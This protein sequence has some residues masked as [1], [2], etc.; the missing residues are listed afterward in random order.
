MIINLDCYRCPKCN[1]A[2]DFESNTKYSKICP[3]CKVEMNFFMNWDK[4]TEKAKRTK[5]VKIYKPVQC[6]YCHSTKTNKISVLSRSMSVGLFG[7]GSSKIGKQW[8]CENCKSD[9]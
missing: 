5:Q 9:F 8:H 1:K 2:Y 3:K 6:P 7:F 4:D